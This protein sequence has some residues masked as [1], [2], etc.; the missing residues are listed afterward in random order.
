MTGRAASVFPSDAEIRAMLVRRIDVQAQGVGLVVGV[1]DRTGCRVIAHGE[2]VKGGGRAVGGETLFEIGSTT[3]AFT[4]LLLAEMVERGEVGLDDPVAR[5]LPAGVTAPTRAGRQITLFDLATHTSGLPA[6]DPGFRTTDPE[7]PRELAGQS[8]AL[9]DYTAERLY[10][11]LSAWQF[12]RDIGA[13][14][15]YSNLGLGLLGHLLARRAGVDFET[16]LAERIAG[17]LGLADTVITPAAH[18][19]SR[20]ASGHDWRLQPVAD[21]RLQ[22]LAGAGALRSTA[23]DL[24][25]FLA[26][27]LG[28]VETPLRAAMDAQLT[29]R[30]PTRLS[31]MQIS[32]GWHV[33]ATASGEIV[34]HSGA[35]VGSLSFLGF[36]RQRGCGVVVL[37]NTRE[38]GDEN[39][40][41]RLLGPARS[42]AARR[43][44]GA[45][46]LERLVGRY[47]LASGSILAV[48]REGD[49]LFAQLILG[50]RAHARPVREI[51]PLTPTRFGWADASVEVTF[52]GEEQATGIVIHSAGGDR[53]GARLG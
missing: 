44:L 18:Q 19:R 40:G 6:M 9:A 20:L 15:L 7:H 12:T 39:L 48:T 11:F 26:A 35:T 38:A 10:A 27:E 49:R 14:Y 31:R 34:S 29:P 52:V 1:I 24:L 5:Y 2:M 28:Y 50:A 30:R 42:G 45:A 3:K 41:W 22:V 17:P 53:R 21:M 43:K 16:L 36:D 13:R 47:G 23:D 4:A 51:F 37:N 46:A 32:L 25:A 8:R 33:T